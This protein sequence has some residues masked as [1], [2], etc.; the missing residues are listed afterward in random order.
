MHTIK[1]LRLICQTKSIG[2]SHD[3]KTK[4]D[5]F[6]SIYF[7]WIFLHIG[8]SPNAV[9]VFSGIL[10]VC[11]G[12]LLSV[13]SI[14]IVILGVLFLHLYYILDY[15]DGEIARFYKR[16]SITGHFL[17]W[18]MLFVRDSAM[19]MGLAIGAYSIEPNK[20]ILICGF[21]ASLTPIM[22]KS[23]INCGWTVISWARFRSLKT[24]EDVIKDFDNFQPVGENPGKSGQI[25]NNRSKKSLLFLTN[26]LIKSIKL[27][28]TIIFQH[29][30]SPIL[31]LA[32]CLLQIMLKYTMMI[33]IDFRPVLIIY[34]GI[35]G[36]IFI[37]VKII[38]LVKKNAF[39]DGYKRLFYKKNDITS[40][41]YFF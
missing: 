13:K 26:Y 33:S 6:F 5:L 39:E 38:R 12:I 7:T 1:E 10:A 17:D 11:G 3:K 18:Y 22:E 36:P 40:E 19:F 32:L 2:R 31:L 15:C 35:I 21:L 27:F 37:L 4:V 30:W 16:Q 20:I 14:N 41:D 25:I 9:T 23:I 8:I 34:A 28:S 24:G 29:H